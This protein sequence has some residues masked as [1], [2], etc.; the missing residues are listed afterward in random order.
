MWMIA[1]L[2]GAALLVASPAR[3]Q[4]ADDVALPAI[5]AQLFRPSIDAGGMLWTDDAARARSGQ[6]SGRMLLSYANEPLVFTFDSGDR[7]EVVSGVTQADLVGGYTLGRVRLGVDVP[8]YLRASGTAFD[9]RSSGL[10]DV[11]A[12]VKVS[13]LTQ[14]TAPI[15][16]AFGG[17]LAVPTATLDTALGNPGVAWELQAIVDRRLGPALLALNLGSRGVPSATLEDLAWDDQLLLRAGA[18]VDLTDAAGVSAELAGSFTY[19]ELGDPQA[20]PLETLV[21]GWL[22][23]GPRNLVLRGGLGTGLTTGVGTP[24]LRTV[25][26][27]AYEARTGIDTDSDGIID[28]MDDCPQE[29]EDLDGYR[30]RDGCPEP[31]LIRVTFTDTARN[32]TEI[33][34]PPEVLTLNGQPL[35]R[36]TTLVPGGYDL[37]VRIP[38]Y[39]ERIERINVPDGESYNLTLP[40]EVIRP[41]Q[42]QVRVVG[43]GGQP[44]PGATWRIGGVDQ[45]GIEQ[46]ANKTVM[47][48]TYRISAAAAGHLK[49]SEITQIHSDLETTV[50]LVLRPTTV[51]VTAERIDIGGKIYFQSGS[52]TIKPESFPL[53]EDLVQ[54]LREYPEIQKLRIEGHTDQN[55]D[56]DANQRLSELRA[57]AVA[58]YLSEKGIDPARLVSVGFGE[59]RPIDRR[60]GEAADAR[61]RRVD[62]FVERWVD[63]PVTLQA[64]AAAGAAEPPSE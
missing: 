41:G 61:N 17:R 53:L 14:A 29:A 46:L 27:V 15:G 58:R 33:T 5:N 28:S 3:A 32:N 37:V 24:R 39:K 54:I 6:V 23:P 50:E 60:S 16:L 21:G 11:A 40:M 18:A 62:F 49:D 10:G 20:T 36:E 35:T 30:D 63:E 59:S 43:P 45:G 25:L 34:T 4:T 8:L 64:P 13:A 56:A 47:P 48:G 26:A 55:G 2:A 42:L 57:A 31:T 44:I 19:V 1:G 51:T 38:G 22:R 52:D 12:D 9:G 7:I